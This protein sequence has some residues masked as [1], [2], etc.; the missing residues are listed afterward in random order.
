MLCRA[1]ESGQ[2]DVK[3]LRHFKSSNFE[4]LTSKSIIL[5]YGHAVLFLLLLYY[6]VNKIIIILN[7]SII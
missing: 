4:H 7:K 6:N 5:Q 1:W 3:Q 2:L